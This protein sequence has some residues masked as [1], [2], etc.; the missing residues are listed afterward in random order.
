MFCSLHHSNEMN[1]YEV[2]QE[3]YLQ[4]CNLKKPTAKKKKI[5]IRIFISEL[6]KEQKEGFFRSQ[7]TTCK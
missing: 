4:L 3:N 7:K 6:N 2:K 5:L 1:R